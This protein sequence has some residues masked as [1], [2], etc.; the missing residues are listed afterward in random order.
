MPAY[1]REILDVLLRWTHL[2]AGIM[3]VGNSMLFNWLDRNLVMPDKPKEGLIGEIWMVHSGG[4]YQVEKKRLAPSQMPAVL[5]WFKWQAYT[6]WITGF[7]LLGVVYHMGGAGM[8]VDVQS[9]VSHGTA[10][11]ISIGVL[12]VGWVVY[13]GLWRSP[14]GRM[15]IVPVLISI[16]LL[17][18]AVF[19]LT[20]VFGGRAAFIHV[21]A[22]MGTLMAA[23][24]AMHIIPSQRELVA[25]TQA[26]QVQDTA[27]SVRAKTRSIHNN[28]MT[29]PVLFTMLSNH[30]SS[31]YGSHLN[32]VLLCLVITGGALVRHWMNIRFTFPAWRV[33]LASTL[34]VAIGLLAFLTNL[35]A[36]GAA[37]AAATGERVSFAA[38]RMVLGQRCV[39]CH[40][41]HPTDD[42]NR[43]APAGVKF[44]EPQLIAMYKDR[45]RVRA[46]VTRTMPNGNKTGMTQDERD[47]LAKWFAQG[48]PIE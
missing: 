2:I 19:G 14:L 25:A 47:L 38:V 8:L 10:V 9:K 27:L 20:Q 43:I 7:L 1:L 29:F 15:G 24:V 6:T 31:I 16:A 5:H 44:D 39:P 3:W 28:Y 48:A 36:P 26:G 35:P 46:V 12:V 21:G 30:F 17:F 22:L 37:A 45:I 4:F 41:A 34:A 32:A 42:E 11:G 18:G 23:N 33:A 13:D 40:A